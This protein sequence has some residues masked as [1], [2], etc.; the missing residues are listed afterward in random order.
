MS[1][2]SYLGNLLEVEGVDRAGLWDV[3]Q[4]RE[5]LPQDAVIPQTGHPDHHQAQS[6]RETA[7]QRFNKPPSLSQHIFKALLS[8]LLR[9]QNKII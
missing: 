7:K 9:V 6:C 5:F 3:N 4:S 8:A 2:L 1:L